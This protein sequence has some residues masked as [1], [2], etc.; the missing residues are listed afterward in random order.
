MDALRKRM[1]RATKR[2]LPKRKAE[3]VERDELY[4]DEDEEDDCKPVV[5]RIKREPE[6]TYRG[7]REVVEVVD[8]TLSD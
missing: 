8:L 1:M 4:E 7:K 5:K 3:S 2:K 6:I